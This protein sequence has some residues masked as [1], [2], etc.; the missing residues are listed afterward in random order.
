MQD[1]IIISNSYFRDIFKEGC[2]SILEAYSTKIHYYQLLNIYH[3]V[4]VANHPKMATPP[5]SLIAYI[6]NYQT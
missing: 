3:I 1:N 5:Y 6:F 2:S 4:N